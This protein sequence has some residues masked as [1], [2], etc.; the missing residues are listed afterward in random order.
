MMTSPSPRNDQLHTLLDQ[1]LSALAAGGQGLEDHA[2]RLR[3]ILDAAPQIVIVGRLKA[4]KS[5]LVN[6]LVGAK[7]AATAALECTNAVAI[8]RDGAPARAEV[9]GIDGTTTRQ[10]LVEG[11]LVELGRPVT[12]VAYVDRFLPSARLADV[13]LIDTPGLATLTADND[14]ATRRALIDGYAQTTTASVDADAVVFLGDSTPRRD[15]LEF[16]ASLGFTPLTAMGVLSRADGFGEGAMGREDPIDAAAA[17]CVQ[18]SEHLASAVYRVQ[19]VAGLL[20]ETARSGGI[21]QAL[22]RQLAT[23]AGLEREELLAELES[24]QSHHLPTDIRNTLLD[25]VGEYGMIAGAPVA[26]AGGAVALAAWLEE[27]SGI[28][29]VEQILREELVPRAALA[30]VLRIVDELERLAYSHPARDHIRQVQEILTT[31]PVM[32]EV[33]LF[34]AYRAVVTHHPQSPLIGLLTSLVAGSSPA[35][36]MGL[37]NS[38]SSSAVAERSAQTLATLHSMAMVTLSAAEEDARTRAV[39]AVQRLHDSVAP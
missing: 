1:A 38:A 2:Q 10:D 9:V 35:E 20:A 11:M 25:T 13:S 5:T 15:E 28:T 14:A 29:A 17:H 8:Y 26:A 32:A 23:L 39:Q 3:L 31:Q 30:R 36:K 33:L 4:G 7:V 6:A 19:P 22:A 18:L 16:L 27:R 12:E 21:T 34:G 24:E 37:A